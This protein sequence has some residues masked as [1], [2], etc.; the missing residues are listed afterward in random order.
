MPCDLELHHMC[1]ISSKKKLRRDS[2]ATSPLRDFL[3]STPRFCFTFYGLRGEG[4]AHTH[5]YTVR[6]HCDSRLCFYGFWRPQKTDYPFLYTPA[7]LSAAAVNDAYGWFF[8]SWWAHRNAF[9]RSRRH[10]PC[11]GSARWHRHFQ[12]QW[13]VMSEAVCNYSLESV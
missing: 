13:R 11:T 3:A 9:P 5:W 8:S 4:G 2:W 10:T 6:K 1:L 12:P 7:R